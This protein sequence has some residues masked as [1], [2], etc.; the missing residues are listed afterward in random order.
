MRSQIVVTMYN[1]A[2]NVWKNVQDKIRLISHFSRTFQSCCPLE[3]WTTQWQFRAEKRFSQASAHPYRRLKAGFSVCWPVRL[4]LLVTER[5][6]TETEWN[7]QGLNVCFSKSL[8]TFVWFLSF[9]TW[10]ILDLE[11]PMLKEEP[12]IP[13]VWGGINLGSPI[14]FL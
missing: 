7:A 8:F 6:L 12:I 10:I 14:H 9:V 4:C 3:V 5:I 11:Q 13:S 1:N 2:E